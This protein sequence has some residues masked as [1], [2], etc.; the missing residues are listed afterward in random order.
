MRV[1]ILDYQAGNL[2][3]VRRALAHLGVEAEV[4]DDPARIAIADRVIFP[5]VGAAASC[6]DNLTA[7]GLDRAIAEFAATGRPLL[8]VCIGMQLLF[9]RSEEDGGVACLGLLPGTVRRFRPSEPTLKVPHMGWSDVTTVADPLFDG[10]DAGSHFYFV[11]SYFCAPSAGVAV[12]ASADYGG[13]FC[14]G[15]RRGNVAAVQ[16]HP[17][18]SGAYG[19]RLLANFLKP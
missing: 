19:L 18:K 7:R 11:H 9:E 13:R 12:I 1:A 2:A 8:G 5:G 17:E 14:V 16:F 10:I 6:M 4:T 3:S 15:V